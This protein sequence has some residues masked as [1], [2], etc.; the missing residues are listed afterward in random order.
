MGQ[1]EYAQIIG[2]L[3]HLMNFSKPN[4]AYAMCRLSRYTH[5]PNNDHW[6]ALARLMKYL[7]DTMNYGILCNGF[8][9][10]LEGYKMLTGSL[11]QMR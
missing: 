11:I 6:G 9:A 3:I 4:K 7:R 10:V 5:N 2:S 8:P 1:A